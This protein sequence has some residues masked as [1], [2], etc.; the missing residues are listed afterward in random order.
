MHRWILWQTTRPQFVI[1]ECRSELKVKHTGSESKDPSAE[2]L[3]VME[4]LGLWKTSQNQ[5]WWKLMFSSFP[6]SV[7]AIL[8]NCEAAPF[9]IDGCTS[10]TV[11]E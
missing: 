3:L 11:L 2:L 6:V 7:G 5:K 1:G 8:A 9:A 10:L 4:L